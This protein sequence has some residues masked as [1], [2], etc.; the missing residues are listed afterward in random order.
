MKFRISL[1]FTFLIFSLFKDGFAQPFEKKFTPED[2]I[3]K[4]KEAAVHEMYVHGIPA[5]ITLAQGMLESG[6]GNSALAVYANNHFGIKC[7]SDWKGATYFADD[8]KENECF[9]KYENASTSYKDHSAFLV[10]KSRYASLFELARNDYKGWA[11]GLKEAGYATNPKYA[12]LLIEI[13]EKYEL[14]HLDKVESIASRNSFSRKLS[15]KPE[16]KIRPS[17]KFNRSK[18][19]VSKKGD[20]FFKIALEFDL[21]LIDVLKYND[22]GKNENVSPGQ[23]IYIERKRRKALEPYHVVT[24]GETM[25]SIAQLHG[26][27]LHHLYKKNRM[28]PDQKISEGEMLYLRHKRPKKN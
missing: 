3:L 26:I 14:F 13:I 24:K 8:D 16:M 9:R 6:N 15:P 20:S 28:K 25:W 27:R 22:L 2:Y 11:N 23:K 18:F 5:S 7:H 21:E 4:Y 1:Y 12:N 17:M 10:G 19:I